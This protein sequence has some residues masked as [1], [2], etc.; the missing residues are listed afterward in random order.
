MVLRGIPSDTIIDTVT[1][2]VLNGWGTE[3]HA[4]AL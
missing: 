1:G 3:S 4:A 2:I